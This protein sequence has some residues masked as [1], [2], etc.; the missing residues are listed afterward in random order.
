MP[1]DNPQ[2]QKMTIQQALELAVQHHQADR[3]ADAEAI[4]RWVLAAEPKHADALH[5]LGV[6]AHE[7]GQNPEALE[8]INRA[9]AFNP[10]RA[11]YY[12]S[13]GLVLEQLGR[14]Q[15]AV[16]AYG[17]ALEIN[18]GLATTHNNLGNILLAQGRH[19]AAVKEFHA[20]LQLK[21]GFAEAYNNLGNA[22]LALGQDEPAVAAC[23]AAIQIQPN[24]ALA[25]NNLGN[26]L[27]QQG[28]FG[29]AVGAYQEALRLNPHYAEAYNNLGNALQCLGRIDEAVAAY[30]AALQI[31]PS[32]AQVH[33]N[34][35]FM[36]YAQGEFAQA[37]AAYQEALRINPDRAEV[38]NNLGV[39]LHSQRHFD[40]AAAAF[41]S[42]I[43]LKPDDADYHN[44]LGL[45]LMALG[46]I[47][48]A[49]ASCRAALAINPDSAA[50]HSTLLCALNYHWG[51]DPKAIHEE[52]R[53]WNRR[54]AEELKKFI[55][56]HTHSDSD[57]DD[58]ERRLKI[59]YVSADFH[60]HASAFFLDP[61]LRSHDHQHFEIFC[62]AQAARPDHLTRKFQSYAD[63]WR[64]I[65][66]ISDQ[67]LADQIRRDGIDI[68]V[69]LKLHTL[70]HRL[71]VFA[72][73]PAPV[74]VTWLG[75]PGSTG[76][77]T[78]DYRLTDH[79]LDPP[80][81]DDA[82]YSE[83]SIRLPDTFWC[84]DP[85]IEESGAPAPEINEPPAINN[86]YVTFGCLNN[87]CKI[88]EKVLQIWAGVL[89]A[90]PNSRLLLLAPQGQ[91]REQVLA[92]LNHEGVAP[93][94]IE[95]AAHQERFEY[96]KLYNRIDCGL[97]TFPC[98][99]HTTSLD[100]LW[101]GVP[102]VSLS[103]KT[104]V[105]RAG[106]SILTNIGLPELIAETPEQYVQMAVKLAG[107]L[108][109]LAELRSTLR[110]RM[111]ASPLMDAGRF[112]RNVEAAYR[113][114]WRKWC[115]E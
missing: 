31:K 41:E 101:M 72:R 82:W 19:D 51:F 20:A 5:L 104:A 59:G 86:G 4:Y 100:A 83:E 13:L 93:D 79:Y 71:K 108:P 99:G 43:G 10:R 36:L 12:N 110:Q 98:N 96:L 57:R 114:M 87:F 46:R 115:N 65:A 44:N 15:A 81:L 102:V 77:D 58:P 17:T 33:N 50:I 95:F 78:I 107:E 34:L 56:P 30:R 105:G 55:Q 22:L 18:P 106:R 29:E 48:Q 61:L 14:I 76:L 21:P 26:A 45:T 62:Y 11:I 3:L 27:K 70:N 74:Q 2:A 112:A 109:R 47:D 35:G 24:Y 23:R 97:D 69:D 73:K 94:R 7:K 91:A 38:H 90:R 54:H 9:I 25:H 68:L 52:L 84:Y 1:E 63:Q 53:Q 37:R 40:Q 85:L 28:K 92:V 88:N 32:L 80:G 111:R 8:Y 16:S 67:E 89:G 64:N 66:G 42:A 6:V 60:E 75:Y 49:V 39:L 113:N 103:G